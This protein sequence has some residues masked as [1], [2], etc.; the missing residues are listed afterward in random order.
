MPWGNRSL[1]S[2]SPCQRW[3]PS[4]IWMTSSPYGLRWRA[5]KHDRG[6]VVVDHYLQPAV[7]FAVPI[8]REHGEPLPRAQDVADVPGLDLVP[9]PRRRG[10]QSPRL[11]AGS[12]AIADLERPPFGVEQQPE[13]IV[14]DH[15]EAVGDHQR[16]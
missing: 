9:I 8:T 14:V 11:G 10:G 2:Q 3:N 5:A 13:V 7:G 12:Q 16:R 15:P 6:K 1:P 4:S